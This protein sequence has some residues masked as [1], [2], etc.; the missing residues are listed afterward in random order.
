VFA[1]QNQQMMQQVQS[2]H[3]AGGKKLFQQNT[4]TDA[5]MAKNP[6]KAIAE[7]TEG[8][9][10]YLSASPLLLGEPKKSSLNQSNVLLAR[11]KESNFNSNILSKIDT[12]YLQ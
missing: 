7:G 11:I 6:Y 5:G 8:G 4:T 3:N 10:Y 1:S 9:G 12:D 2:H